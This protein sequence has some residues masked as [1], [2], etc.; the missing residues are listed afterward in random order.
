M[1][2]TE[3]MEGDDGWT[4][5]EIQGALEDDIPQYFFW[6]CLYLWISSPGDKDGAIG[7]GEDLLS[8]RAGGRLKLFQG[9]YYLMI[10]V[11]ICKFIF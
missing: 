7:G 9:Y 11:M 8:G 3:V 2:E 1:V 4:L 6:S 10:K 5:E